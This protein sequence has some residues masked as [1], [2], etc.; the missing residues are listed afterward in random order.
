MSISNEDIHKNH[1]K[2][3]SISVN[4]V[5]RYIDIMGKKDKCEDCPKISVNGKHIKE[6]DNEKYLGDYITKYANPKL[7]IQD[8]KRK[9]YGILSE[10]SAILDDIPLGVK[11]CEI[12]LTLRQAWFINGCLYN[13]EV[14][15]SVNN[16]DLKCLEIIDHKILRV[17]LGAHRG[18]PVEM[19]YLETG[20]MPLTNV[21]TVR[22]LSYLQY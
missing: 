5:M 1:V 15:H 18:V 11:R 9:G 7:T 14:W 6:S 10:I 13:S 16:S 8:R 2:T 22:R 4:H 20:A 12:G 19:L 21:I 17:I 3:L